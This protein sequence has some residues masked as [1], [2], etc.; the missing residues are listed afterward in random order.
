[1]KGKHYSACVQP[2]HQ[3]RES[4]VAAVNLPLQRRISIKAANTFRKK[5]Q[6]MMEFRLIFFPPLSLFVCLLFL[7]F[8][9]R[10]RTECL[11]IPRARHRSRGPQ[12]TTATKHNN[13]EKA[14]A[15]NGRLER[16]VLAV[17]GEEQEGGSICGGTT[18]PVSLSTFPSGVREIDGLVSFSSLCPRISRIEKCIRRRER[19]CNGTK[20][21]C[22]ST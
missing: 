7:P 2:Q 13:S 6:S 21:K 14:R 5:G 4:E 16:L 11:G 8:N 15:V 17:E 19:G 9:L 20:A 12:K 18:T 10:H 22:P 3:C 1:M